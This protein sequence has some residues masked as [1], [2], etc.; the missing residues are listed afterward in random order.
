LQGKNGLSGFFENFGKL[1]KNTRQ[2]WKKEEFLPQKG[3]KIRI[4]IP[5][6]LWPEKIISGTGRRIRLPKSNF[7]N[8]KMVLAHSCSYLLMVFGVYVMS[9]FP[10]LTLVFEL[11]MTSYSYLFIL[12]QGIV[13]TVEMSKLPK[14][15]FIVFYFP[16]SIFDFRMMKK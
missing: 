7:F 1:R 12:I 2:I 16:F 14:L 6:C 3:T 8:L 10:I 13:Y 5:C 15:T 11:K 4:W 9:K